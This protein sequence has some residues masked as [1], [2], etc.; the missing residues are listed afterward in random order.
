MV[1]RIHNTAKDIKAVFL[2]L[3]ATILH[4]TSAR[5]KTTEDTERH[6]GGER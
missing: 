5:N 2:Y 3:A 6:R 4:G 1:S